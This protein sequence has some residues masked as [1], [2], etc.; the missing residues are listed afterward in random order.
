MTG[1]EIDEQV[2]PGQREALEESIETIEALASDVHRLSRQL[3][4][5]VLDDLGLVAALRSECVRRSELSSA[6]IEFEVEGSLPQLSGE[7]RL[8]IFRVAQESMQNAVKHAGASRILVR[9]SEVPASL[10]L[11]VQ[12]DGRGFEPTREH[13][14]GIG[15]SSM[16]ERMHLVEGSLFIESVPGK[17]TTVRAIA[18]SSP[19]SVSPETGQGAPTGIS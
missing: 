13:R 7:A 11:I 9:V 18:P 4:P 19:A 3:H 2:E 6:Q 16:R 15:L 17:G 5:A 12:D 10:E 1:D 14:S 8:A